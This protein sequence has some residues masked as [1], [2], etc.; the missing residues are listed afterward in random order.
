MSDNEILQF[1]PFISAFD[2]GFW[3]KLSKKKLDDF[4]LNV[5]PIT[6]KGFYSVSKY[7]QRL[8]LA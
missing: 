3:Y 7:K 4:K 1:A 8:I 5:E 6:I 2:A